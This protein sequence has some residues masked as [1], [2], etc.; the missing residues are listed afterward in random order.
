MMDYV[1][2][3][4]EMQHKLGVELAG[5]PSGITFARPV[6]LNAEHA[7]Q[8]RDGLRNGSIHWVQVSKGKRTEIADELKML[9]GGGGRKRKD[10]ATRASSAAAKKV[11]ERGSDS[12][13]DSEEEDE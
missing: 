6:K 5:W 1:N 13:D 4:L 3:Q 2:Y 12:D 10:V 11:D 8:I 7:H 9:A